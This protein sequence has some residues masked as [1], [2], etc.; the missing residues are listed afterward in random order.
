MPNDV[1]RRILGPIDLRPDDG[2]HIANR[3]LQSTRRR[4]LRLAADVDG[5]P[6]EGQG[7]GRVDARGGEE[8]ANVG[9][10]GPSGGV[11]V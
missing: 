1:P 9:D 3:D 10:T 7:H 6:G 8:G 2:A 5:G 11:F 4:A